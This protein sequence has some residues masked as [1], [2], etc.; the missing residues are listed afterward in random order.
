MCTVLSCSPNRP[1][2]TSTYEKGSFAHL[3]YTKIG[4]RPRR[5]G[6]NHRMRVRGFIVEIKV[7]PVSLTFGTAAAFD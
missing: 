4:L 5:Y 1:A 6:L 3:L 2:P 7:I